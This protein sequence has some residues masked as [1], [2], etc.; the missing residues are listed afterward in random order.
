MIRPD[1]GWATPR[2]RVALVV[3][4]YKKHPTPDEELSLGHLRRYLADHPVYLMHPVGLRFRT[5]FRKAAFE[6]RCITG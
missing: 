5:E 1:V 2:R 3:P 4:F 6:D